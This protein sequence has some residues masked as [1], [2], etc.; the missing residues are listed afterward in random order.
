MRTIVVT[1]MAAAPEAPGRGIF[2]RDQ[3][4]ALRRLGADVTLT[5]FAPGDYAQAVRRLRGLA[6]REG[7]FDLV[8]AH[9]GLTAFPA[10]AIPARARVLTVH[11][12]DVRH[13]RTG[14]LTRLVA[15]RMDLVAA[16][17]HDLGVDL[18]GPAPRGTPLPSLGR[19]GLP[20][21]VLPCGVAVDRFRPIPRAEARA[22][23][24]LPTDEPCVLFPADPGRAGKRFDLAQEAVDGARLHTLGTVDPADVP[25]WMN[26]ASVVVLPSD[27]EGFGLAVLEALACDVP[28]ITTPVGIHPQALQGV[29]GALCAPYERDRWRRAIAAALAQPDPRVDGRSVVAPWSADRMAERVHD[30]W[31]ALLPDVG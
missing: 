10:L 5:E 14:R 20:T 28:V 18:A 2:V 1:N 30:A 31:R 12:T 3:V 24:G 26:A 7:P 9:F 13:P 23:L 25:L 16:V 11:G 19:R 15:R 27:A 8:H 22:R 4:A 6:R 21:A 29:A 17:S